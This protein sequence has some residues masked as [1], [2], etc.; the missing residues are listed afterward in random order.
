M[1][2]TVKFTRSIEGELFESY[3]HIV[4]RLDSPL[5]ED[6]RE[7]AKFIDM[8][9]DPLMKPHLLSL[10]DTYTAYDPRNLQ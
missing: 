3:T 2:K 9:F 4:A 7:D 8:T 10:K 1:S 6:R 5:E